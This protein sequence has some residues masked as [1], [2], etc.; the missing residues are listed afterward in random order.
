MKKILTLALLAAA[1]SVAIAADF[2]VKP[3]V[4][5]LEAQPKTVLLVGNS[6]MYYNCGVNG[7]L[8]GFA[9]SKGVKLATT[10]ATIGGA[11]LDWHDVKSYLRPNGLRSYSTTNDGT[12]RLVF[13]QYP[14]GKI[15]DA[16]ILQDNSQGPVHPELKKFFRKYAAIHSKDIRE[17]GAEP[18]FL[19]TW[20]YHGRPEMTAQLMDATTEVANENRAMTIPAGLAFARALK[21]RPDLV[22]TQPDNRH[23]TMLGTYLEGAVMFAALTH[24]SPEGSSFRGGCAM[25]LTDKDAAYLQK[26]AWETVKEFYGW[27]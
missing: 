22:M 15:F 5:E 18:L 17:T 6:F 19:A 4:T 23:P 2:N 16:V 3:A 12:N 14:D 24:M 25:A 8:G 9:K 21:G 7:I 20:A 11:G 1:C 27:K 10:M 13:H 26:V